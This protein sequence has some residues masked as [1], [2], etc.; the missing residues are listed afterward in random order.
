MSSPLLR[1]LSRPDRR[2]STLALLRGMA[3]G[4]SVVGRTT[5]SRHRCKTTE[6]RI[7][8][9]R[10]VNAH[11]NAPINIMEY[12]FH[13]GVI[14]VNSNGDVDMDIPMEHLFN[15]ISF[16]EELPHV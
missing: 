5:R 15:A 13:R 8:D 16:I 3:D 2:R 11:G 10:S 4:D 14:H 9:H 7:K 6:I 12:L 1:Y